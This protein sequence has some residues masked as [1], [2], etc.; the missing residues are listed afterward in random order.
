MPLLGTSNHRSLWPKQSYTWPQ[1]VSPWVEGQVI[2]CVIGSQPASQLSSCNWASQPVM[3]QDINLSGFGLVRYQWQEDWEPNHIEPQH[4]HWFPLGSDLPDKATQVTEMS[5]T[6]CY[7]HLALCLVTICSFVSVLPNHISCAQC[8]E[9]LYRLYSLQINLYISFPPSIWC[10]TTPRYY[11]QGTTFIY[12]CD[13]TEGKPDPT[14]IHMS[15]W[16]YVLLLWVTRY[17]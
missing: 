14:A 6:A 1:H 8:R 17:I 16:P 12:T 3:S 2:L 7:I 4:S 5:S 15:C 10:I 13:V 11:F 9:M